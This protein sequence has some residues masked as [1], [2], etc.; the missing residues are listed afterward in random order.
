MG[1]IGLGDVGAAA[2]L[3][4][5]D[6]RGPAVLVLGDSEEARE[7]ARNAADSAGCRVVDSIGI[8]EAL[9][10]I[11]RQVLV[12]AVLLNLDGDPGPS[13]DPLLERLNAAAAAG[14]N[15]SVVAAPFELVDRVAALTDHR[16]VVQLCEASEADWGRAIA[17]AS[18]LEPLRFEDI[19][20]RPGVPRLQQLSEEVGRIA[21]ILA[22]LSEEEAAAAEADEGGTGGDAVHAGLVRQIIRARRLRDQY[23][24]GDLFAD[25]AWDMLLDLLAAKLE[26]RR[27]AVSSLC[28]AAAVPPTTALRWIKILCEQG[29]ILRVT[30]PQDGRR[31]FIEMAPDTSMMMERYLRAAQRISPLIV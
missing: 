20:K 11:D 15:G 23:L 29:L 1:A 12:D 14:R 21:S 24:K 13:L 19:T 26:D 30:D 17:R 3:T 2:E 6:H 8:A 28:I 5:Y 25:P 7:R 16:S 27:V 18:T 9:E 22:S 31:V 4:E 10:R